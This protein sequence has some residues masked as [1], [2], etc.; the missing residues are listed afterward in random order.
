M[1]TVDVYTAKL[2]KNLEIKKLSCLERDIEVQSILNLKVKKEKYFAW[3]LLEF[4]IAKSMNKKIDELV[5]EKNEFGKWLTK[6]FFFSISHSKDVVAVAISSEEVGVDIEL[7]TKPKRIERILT[8]EEKELFCKLKEDKRE[9]FLIEKWSQKESVFKRSNSKGFCPSKINTL[10][11]KVSSKKI[12]IGGNEY[13]LS[14]ATKINDIKYYEN[15]L[16]KED[17]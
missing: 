1:T 7:L 15:V 12:L 8:E 6:D 3:K 5:F 4:A 14:V 17:N 2:S 9:E 11:E 16:I 10:K 13:I